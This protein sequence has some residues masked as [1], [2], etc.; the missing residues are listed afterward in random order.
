MTE[1]KLLKRINSF[2]DL[3]AKRRKKKAS[4]LKAII[5]KLKKKEKALK[6][7]CRKISKGKKRETLEKRCLVLHAKR[8]KGLIALK[9]IKKG[10]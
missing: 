2:F 3:S 5:G 6:A 8:K 7:K 4:E 10:K 9:K 1:S